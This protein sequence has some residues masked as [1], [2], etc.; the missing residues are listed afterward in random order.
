MNTYDKR[1]R[2]KAKPQDEML[3]DVFHELSQPLTTLECG[4]ELG[5]RCDTTVAQLRKRLSMLL[6]AAQEMHQRLVQLRTRQHK[7]TSRECDAQNNAKSTR[8]S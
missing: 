8:H 6:E 2:S 1:V 3:S 7:F 5:L 4:L